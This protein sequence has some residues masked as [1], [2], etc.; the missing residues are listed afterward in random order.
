MTLPLLVAS[1]GIA[2]SLISTIFASYVMNI[3]HENDVERVLGYQL[4]ICT[5]LMTAAIYII[6]D[7]YLPK[8]FML[9]NQLEIS[10]AG[11][12]TAMVLGL[13]AGFAISWIT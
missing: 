2:I 11:V 6:C 13:W 9:E 3:D 10:R 12:Y 1:T 4:K 8:K 5:I 7:I